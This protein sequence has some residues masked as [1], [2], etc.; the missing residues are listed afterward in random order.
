MRT[1]EVGLVLVALLLPCAAPDA[2]A[3]DQLVLGKQFVAKDPIPP[4]TV[5]RIVKLYAKELASPDTVVGDPTVGGATLRVV[6]NGGTS[7]DQTFNLDASGWSPISTLGFKYNNKIP[8]G[9]V[10]NGYIKKTP[11]GVFFIKMGIAGKY[12]ALNVVPPNPGTD[13]GFALTIGGGDTYCSNFGGAAGGEL[14]NEPAGNPFK[15]F[16]VKNAIAETAC[17]P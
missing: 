4:D 10:K 14:R 12:G 11:S 16:A 6:A 5:K 17:L 2:G 7:S 8:G 13:G 1:I 3:A 15:L 9:A